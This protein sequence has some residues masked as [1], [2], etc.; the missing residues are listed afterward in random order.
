[1]SSRLT[2]EPALPRQPAS[3]IPTRVTSAE[4]SMSQPMRTL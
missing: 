1:M 2:S 3:G 4:T